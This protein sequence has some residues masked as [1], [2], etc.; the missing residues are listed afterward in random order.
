MLAA[1]ISLEYEF[2]KDG[3]EL[4]MVAMC[5]E[6]LNF[7]AFEATIGSSE[8]VANALNLIG[9]TQLLAPQSQ[10][11]LAAFP[12]ARNVLA[13]NVVIQSDYAACIQ[14]DSV[15]TTT[16]VS[17][18]QAQDEIQTRQQQKSFYLQTLQKS[19][20]PFYPFLEIT[21]SYLNKSSCVV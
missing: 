6:V 8:S 11:G 5:G 20:A 2:E 17:S 13:N 7:Q 1:Q 3:F 15:G 9:V 21:D 10:Q 12:L 14:T 16:S 18:Q 19:M 4:P